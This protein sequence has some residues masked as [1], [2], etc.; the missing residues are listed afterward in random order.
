MNELLLVCACL[1]GKVKSIRQFEKQ[2]ARLVL[3]TAEINNWA[4]SCQF[5]PR[6][7]YYILYV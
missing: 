3:N 7:H 5:L 2:E 6:N 1:V 4:L